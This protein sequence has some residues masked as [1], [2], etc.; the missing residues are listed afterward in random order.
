MR[1]NTPR[2]MRTIPAGITVT[3][4]RGFNRMGFR[5]SLVHKAWDTQ[6]MEDMVKDIEGDIEE[7]IRH[8]VRMEK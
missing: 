2:I 5:C 6:G 1:V 7:D 8:E 4:R 3:R